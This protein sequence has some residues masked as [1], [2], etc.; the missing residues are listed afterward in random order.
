[1]NKINF[2]RDFP[3]IVTGYNK[4]FSE[5][6][7]SLNSYYNVLL[8]NLFVHQYVFSYYVSLNRCTSISYFNFSKF[9]YNNNT[10]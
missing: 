5:S 1:M 9:T 6:L 10:R 7:E 2:I 8:G 4:R 3:Y